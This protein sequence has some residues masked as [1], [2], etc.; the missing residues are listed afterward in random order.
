[1]LKGL[2]PVFWSPLDKWDYQ[3]AC[4][5]LATL[6]GDFASKLQPQREL[7]DAGQA[8]PYNLTKCAIYLLTS[9]IKRRV[10]IYSLKLRMVESIVE[11]RPE[12]QPSDF[13]PQGELPHNC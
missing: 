3:G 7:D 11:F 9:L 6:D 8:G 10:R 5:A 1:M 4:L 13:T 12:L 2:Y